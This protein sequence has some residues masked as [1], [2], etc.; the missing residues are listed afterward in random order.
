MEIE[1]FTFVSEVHGP[2]KN[3]NHSGEQFVL[4]FE[5]KYLREIGDGMNYILEAAVKTAANE[6][7]KYTVLAG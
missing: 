3:L 2:W 4:R 1:L 6:A 5:T 7:L